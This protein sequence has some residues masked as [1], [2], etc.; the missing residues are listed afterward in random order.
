MK[1]PAMSAACLLPLL[2]TACIHV[3]TPWRKRA[4]VLPPPIHATQK[5]LTIEHP[6]S[7]LTIPSPPLISDITVLPQQTPKPPIKHKKP[8]SN[9]VPSSNTPPPSSGETQQAADE[10]TGVSAI[11]QLSS[12]DPPDL[13]RQT[14]DSI[15]V[16]ERGL[17]TLNRSLSTQERKTAAQISKFLKQARQALN[18]GD[19]AGAN[20]LAAKAKV[21]LS[22]LTQ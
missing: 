22:E 11:G 2:L 15:A 18:T 17:N 16:T 3:H 9:P 21:L 8:P 1:L 14:E 7:T 5:P 10:S 13:W 12:G 6:D 20:T 19:V 4:Q